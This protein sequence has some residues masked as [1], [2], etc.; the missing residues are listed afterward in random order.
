MLPQKHK[1][2]L[3]QDRLFFKSAQRIDSRFFGVWCK[4]C[5]GEFQAQIIVGKK[6]SKK[7][8]VRNKIKRIVSKALAERANDYQGIVVVLVVKQTILNINN[9]QIILEVDGVLNKCR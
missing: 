4:K 6:V 7:A 5:S 9:D 8:V 2:P 3:R 1:Y